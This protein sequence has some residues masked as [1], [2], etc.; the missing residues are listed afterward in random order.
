M[1]GMAATGFQTASMSQ[2][3]S[4]F[5]SRLAE[6]RL[7]WSSFGGLQKTKFIEA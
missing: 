5:F 1:Q 2:R 6:G 4:C 7:G 3:Q